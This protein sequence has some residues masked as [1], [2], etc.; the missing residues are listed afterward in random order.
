[1][2]QLTFLEIQV[3]KKHMFGHNFWWLILTY[4][5]LWQ[6]AWPPFWSSEATNHL[7]N[8][9]SPWKRALK[10]TYG[11][12]HLPQTKLEA[13]KHSNRDVD[14]DDK[15]VEHGGLVEPAAAQLSASAA[16]H[17]G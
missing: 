2:S 16:Q 14:N 5:N 4:P 10:G 17:R 8:E 15:V 11:F 9:K 12:T 6:D 3:T 13:E 7:L 1:M